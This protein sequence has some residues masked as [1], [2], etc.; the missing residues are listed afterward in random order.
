MKTQMRKVAR[1]LIA[2]A[3]VIVI[4]MVNTVAYATGTV[5]VLQQQTNALQGQLNNLNG[6]LT[7]LSDEITELAG[8][9]DETNTEI[10]KA[11]LALEAAKVREEVQYDSM[12]LRIKYMYEDGR[13]N[14]LEVLLSSES[15]AEFLNKTQFIS[16]ITEYDRGMLEDLKEIHQTIQTKTKALEETQEKQ[17][18]QQKEMEAKQKQLNDA[19]ASTS[20]E[21]QISREALARAKAAQAAAEEAKRRAEEEEKRAEAAKDKAQDTGTSSSS[22]TDSS[23]TTITPSKTPA[24]SEQKPSSSSETV[25]GSSTSVSS[26]DLVLFACLLECE[27]GSTNY[28]GI[29]AVATVVMN[30]VESPRYEN[31]VRGVIYQKGQFSPSWS[32]SLDRALARGPKDLCLQVAREALAGK[33]LAAV[34]NCYSFRAASGGHAGIVIG[35]N[36]FF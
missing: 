30:R 36:V 20:S 16:S 27:A 5:D 34:A 8:K 24:Q 33:R 21:L 4:G 15:M 31:T 26:S 9:M 1:M 12:K 18:K 10:D 13:S 25:T 35:G 28:D 6:E 14:I 3:C 23:T 17:K 29:L 11:K 7:T 22:K 32:G 2:I 19:I